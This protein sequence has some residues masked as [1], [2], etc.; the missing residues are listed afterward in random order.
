MIKGSG[1]PSDVPPL[2][3]VRAGPG[4]ICRCTSIS[5][6]GFRP[7][8]EGGHS[9]RCRQVLQICTQHLDAEKGNLTIAL[10]RQRLAV[11]LQKECLAAAPR[12][13]PWPQLQGTVKD[14]PRWLK[15]SVSPSPSPNLCT[16]NPLC[17]YVCGTELLSVSASLFVYLPAG[18][19][20]GPTLM[21][22]E[23]IHEQPQRLCLQV[24]SRPGC[25][26]CSILIANP[27]WSPSRRTG[28]VTAY[29]PPHRRGAAATLPPMAGGES[30]VT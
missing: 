14:C 13:W 2:W 8:K 26:E 18:R 17:L 21:L 27:P 15:T 9:R 25:F 5:A 29:S 7:P 28:F 30:S 11:A 3:P 19:K 22:G 16:L 4:R 6:A 12:P 24:H 1:L 23:T 20:A 10:W